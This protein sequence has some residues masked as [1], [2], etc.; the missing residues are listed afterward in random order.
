MTYSNKQI[1]E[2][3]QCRIC[4]AH[5]PMGPRPVFRIHPEAKIAIISQAPGRKV[6]LSGIAWADQ[7]GDRLRDWLGVDKD[8]FYNTPHFAIIP[9]GFCYPGKGKSG[10]LPPRKE[11]APQ[12]HSTLWKMLPNIELSLIIGQYAQ[13]YYLGS[14][15]KKNLTETVRSYEEYLPKYIP[16]PHPSPINIRWRR[17]NEWFEEDVV[18]IVRQKVQAIIQT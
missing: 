12:W 18:P 13:K 1:E 4:E 5:L 9:M 8:T 2:I 11:C 14:N 15:R 16:L 10:D 7:S 6:H 3:K 17:K